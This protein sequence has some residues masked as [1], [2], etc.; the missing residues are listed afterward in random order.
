MSYLTFYV[1]KN[2]VSKH[3]L[4][5]V[6]LITVKARRV[7]TKNPLS[8]PSFISARDKFVQS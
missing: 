2:Y 3:V 7:Y 8:S 6:K 1:F 5:V 4:F